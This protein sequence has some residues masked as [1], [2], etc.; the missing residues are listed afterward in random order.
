MYVRSAPVVSL[1]W[2]HN[3]TFL[4]TVAERVNKVQ[5]APACNQLGNKVYFTIY[6]VLRSIHRITRNTGFQTVFSTYIY[7]C[8]KQA[9]ST[10][11]RRGACSNESISKDRSRAYCG[12]SSVHLAKA[13][14]VEAQTAEEAKSLSKAKSCDRKPVLDLQMPAG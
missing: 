10:W 5:Q 6:G 3:S 2:A 14:T 4:W 1:H 11:C 8:T 13:G 9:Y 12:R 7:I